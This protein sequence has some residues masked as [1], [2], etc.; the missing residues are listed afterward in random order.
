MALQNCSSCGAPVLG[1]LDCLHNRMKGTA[2]VTPIWVRG[3]VRKEAAP[4]ADPFAGLPT[5]AK[6]CPTNV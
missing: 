4:S 1:G 2:T 3:P 6:Q 5:A